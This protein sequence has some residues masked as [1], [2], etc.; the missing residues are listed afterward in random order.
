MQASLCHRTTSLNVKNHH[1]Q[2]PV[3]QAIPRDCQLALNFS[4]LF[5]NGLRARPGR[6]IINPAIRAR[7]TPPDNNVNKTKEEYERRGLAKSTVAAVVFVCT[8]GVMCTNLTARAHW[9]PSPMSPPPVTPDSDDAD[10]SA[11]VERVTESQKRPETRQEKSIEVLLEIFDGKRTQKP[12]RIP[13]KLLDILQQ[14]LVKDEQDKLKE[15]LDQLKT[16]EKTEQATNSLLSKWRKMQHP[17]D[18]YNLGLVLIDLLFHQGDYAEADAVCN[19][20]QSYAPPSDVRPQIRR[21]IINLMLLVG[22][23]EKAKRLKAEILV[24]E[25]FKLIRGSESHVPPEPNV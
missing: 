25:L 1:F 17:S 20:I 3:R 13:M 10:A 21:A 11:P 7:L 24:L 2:H 19:E 12:A 23:T 4:P 15:D 14:E 18:K 5:G 16:T 6:T 22:V 9:W 8:L